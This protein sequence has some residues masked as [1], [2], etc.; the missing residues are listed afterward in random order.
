MFGSF[1]P[2]VRVCRLNRKVLQACNG[3]LRNMAIRA[4]PHTTSSFASKP[5]IPLQPRDTR[6]ESARQFATVKYSAIATLISQCDFCKLAN[7]GEPFTKAS[8]LLQCALALAIS[9]LFPIDQ[10]S[11]REH[12]H[13]QAFPRWSCALR[14]SLA[15]IRLLFGYSIEL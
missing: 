2:S 14:P 13:L 8:S 6:T 7:L 9:R 12:L 10:W 4:R 5:C 15:Y 11:Q 3:A 1:I